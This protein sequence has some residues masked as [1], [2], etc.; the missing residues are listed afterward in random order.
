[1]AEEIGEETTDELKA[2][3]DQHVDLEPVSVIVERKLDGVIEAIVADLRKTKHDQ[4]NQIFQLQ[5]S[6]LNLYM[7]LLTFL[8]IVQRGH[9]LLS[10]EPSDI[11]DTS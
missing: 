2:T 9:R 5:E 1:M 10:V 7:F 4:R 6:I 8:D 3:Y 11:V